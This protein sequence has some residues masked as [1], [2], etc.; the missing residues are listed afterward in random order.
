VRG[1]KR[2]ASVLAASALV[3]AFCS[4]ASA[5]KGEV[6][7]EPVARSAPR[8]Q[9]RIELPPLKR[10]EPIPKPSPTAK[11][12]T[13]PTAK[14]SVTPT[15]K[16]TFRPKPVVKP[17]V[18]PTRTAKKERRPVEQVTR[19]GGYAYCGSAVPAA[20]RCIDQGKLTL[21]YPAGVKTL[22]GHNYMGWYWMD[23][24]PVGRK[25]V[26]SSGSLAGTYLVYGHGW[27]KRGSQGGTF[28]ASGLGASVALQ[29]CT[30][31]GTGFSFLRRL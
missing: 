21:Y 12:P 17:R 9:V 16:S 18:R 22:A 23:D 5:G 19:I 8:Q 13:S 31:T 4:G 26:I 2:A 3:A 11:P 29:T 28:P 14:P 7:K 30:S 25:V 6:G 24:L 15:A 27:A 10:I 20:Q 1:A